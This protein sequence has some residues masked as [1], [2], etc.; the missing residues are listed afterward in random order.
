MIDSPERQV[1]KL[2]TA[3]EQ[4]YY[5]HFQFDPWHWQ[6]ILIRDSREYLHYIQ[7]LK[8]AYWIT[9]AA[10]AVVVIVVVILFRRSINLPVAEIIE[11]INNDKPPHYKGIA[12]FEFLS[13]HIAA[14]MISLQEKTR[15]DLPDPEYHYL[16]S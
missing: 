14:M 8:Y 2:K 5:Y 15:Q 4:F 6:I 13:D 10:L 3:G 1:M 11:S 12:E 9:A 7:K 16:R